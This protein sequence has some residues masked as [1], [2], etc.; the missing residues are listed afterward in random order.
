MHLISGAILQPDLELPETKI[1]VERLTLAKRR[2]RGVAEDGTEFGFELPAPLTHG[3]TIFQ[4]NNTRYVIG[5]KP[6]A[7]VEVSLELTPSAAA[8]IGW[9]I[10]NLHL[11]LAAEPTRL[12]APD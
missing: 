10:G 2:W 4:S 1:V 6:E 5:Q 12:L 7:V 11:E 9:A 8:G 3:D